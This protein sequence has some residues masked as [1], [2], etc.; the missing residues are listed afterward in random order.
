[1]SLETVNE[2]TTCYI[3]AT[4]KDKNAANAAPG[5]ARFRVDCKTTGAVVAEWTAIAS[6]TAIQEIEID[7]T[8]NVMQ[9][10]SNVNELRRVT[11]EG[12]YGADDKITDKYEYQL[13]NMDGI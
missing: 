12:T 2:G 5:S 4:F 11:V 3:T 6:P 13:V 1:M 10:E 7:A 8:L 9:S